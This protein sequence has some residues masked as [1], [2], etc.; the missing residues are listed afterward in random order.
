MEI[1]AYYKGHDDTQ[2]GVSSKTGNA[3]RKVTAI[4]ETI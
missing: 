1:L 2:E 4:F 3:W